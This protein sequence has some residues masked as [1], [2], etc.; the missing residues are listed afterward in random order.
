MSDIEMGIGNDIV[1]SIGHQPRFPYATTITCFFEEFS[2][3]TAKGVFIWMIKRA[4]WK[5]VKKMVS[6]RL[7][8][9]RKKDF[10]LSSNPHDK[11]SVKKTDNLKRCRRAIIEFLVPLIYSTSYSFEDFFRSLWDAR[12]SIIFLH[13]GHVR[14]AYRVVHLFLV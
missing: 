3:S 10:S 11:S 5:R 8:L 2:L 9:F 7:F 4:S 1:C 13:E 14:Y 6:R 12:I